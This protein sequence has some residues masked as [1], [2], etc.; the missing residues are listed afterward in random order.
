MEVYAPN[1]R[2]LSA[3]IKKSLKFAVKN[4]FALSNQGFNLLLYNY[5]KLV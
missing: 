3:F 2:T 4:R 5:F 1:S